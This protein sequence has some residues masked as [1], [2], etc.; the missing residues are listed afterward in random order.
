M[1][2]YDERAVRTADTYG[3]P[4]VD[5]NRG[6]VGDLISPLDLEGPIDGGDDGVAVRGVC[7]GAVGAVEMREGSCW[8]RHEDDG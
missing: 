5:F 4:D 1:L 8:R 3:R 6:F 7:R 2:G